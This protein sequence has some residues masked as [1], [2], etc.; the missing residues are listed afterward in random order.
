VRNDISAYHRAP[1]R[2]QI[3]RGIMSLVKIRENFEESQ[4]PSLSSSRSRETAREIPSGSTTCC[5]VPPSGGTGACRSSSTR[6]LA[7][8]RGGESRDFRFRRPA[9][10]IIALKQ[11][12]IKSPS[13]FRS[14]AFAKAASSSRHLAAEFR[15]LII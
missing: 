4:F 7:L 8:M 14:H 10:E 5:V 2:I 12:R 9:L 1:S 11:P 13:R 3:S 6:N 15:G